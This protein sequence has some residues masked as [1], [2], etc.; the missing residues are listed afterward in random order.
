MVW[1][2]KMVAITPVN[3]KPAIAMMGAKLRFARTVLSRHKAAAK[4][5]AFTGRDSLSRAAE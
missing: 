5:I 1:R 3:G 4:V 2:L